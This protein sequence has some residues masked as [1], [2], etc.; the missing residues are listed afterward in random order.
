MASSP[1]VVC[2]DASLVDLGRTKCCLL[3]CSRWHVV[4]N[5]RTRHRLQQALLRSARAFQARTAEIPHGFH[6]R[7]TIAEPLEVSQSCI[8]SAALKPRGN[9]GTDRKLVQ[10]K[11][12]QP[13][14]GRL[15][16]IRLENLSY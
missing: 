3:G 7:S 11:D 8:P 13:D 6:Q 9:P 1:A 16:I 14:D 5:N 4:E 12:E 10:T 15:A 2:V